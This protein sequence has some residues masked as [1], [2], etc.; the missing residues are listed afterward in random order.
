MISVRLSA[1]Y[2]LDKRGRIYYI[3]PG[4]R[5][6]TGNL[7]FTYAHTLGRHDLAGGNLGCEF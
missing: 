4:S 1:L 5:I 3:G 6:A 2:R 7:I